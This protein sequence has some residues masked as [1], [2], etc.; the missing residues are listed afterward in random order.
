LS[1]MVSTGNEIGRVLE[2]PVHCGG[3][4]FMHRSMRNQK[5]WFGKP[6]IPVG[7]CVKMWGYIR[8]GG[9][10]LS[11]SRSRKGVLSLGLIWIQFLKY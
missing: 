5:K 6:G 8:K 10:I 9:K 3:K 1:I 7:K 11:E 4:S 2:P